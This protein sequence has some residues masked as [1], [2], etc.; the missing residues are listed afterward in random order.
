VVDEKAGGG[1][2]FWSG[3]IWN[4]EVGTAVDTLKYGSRQELGEVEGLLVRRRASY[5]N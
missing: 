5:S 2:I 3:Q 1:S 4:I